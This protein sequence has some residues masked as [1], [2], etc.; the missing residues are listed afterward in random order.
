MIS[1]SL[2]FRRVRILLIVMTAAV[3]AMVVQLIRVQFGTYAPVFAMWVEAAQDTEDEVSPDR[4]LIYDRDGD[5]LATNVPMYYLEIEVFQLTPASRKQIAAV[6]SQALILPYEDLYRQL[7]ID[8]GSVG[9][10]RI[11]LT[12]EVAGE[13][14][15]PITVDQVAADMLRA[16][17]LDPEAPDLSGLKLVPAPKREY[18]ASYLAGHVMGFVNQEGKGYFGV[19][20]FYDDWLAGKP[21]T[22]ERG[23]IP[24]EARLE[25][26]PPAG[27]NLVLTIDLDIQQM[28]EEILREAIENASAESGQILVMDPR[29]GEILG[30]AI[31]PGLNPNNYEPWL[32]ERGVTTAELMELEGDQDEAVINPAVGGQFEPGSTFKVL[33]MAAALDAGVV[34][35]DTEFIDTGQI[36]VGGVRIRNWNGGAW[37]PQTME[38]CMEHSLNVCLAW[39]S[40]E[41]LGASTFYEYLAAFGIGR[42]TGIDVAGEVAGQLRTPRHP[43]W[44]E[45][46]LGTNAFGQGVSVTPVQLL[47]SV[48]AVANDGIMMQP[49]IVRA[50]VGPEGAYWPKPTVLGR[51]ISKETADELNEMLAESIAGETHLA[52]VNGYRLAGKTGTA[53]IPT[54]KGYDERWTIASF[55]GWGPVYD[56]QFIVL[57]RIDKP[58]SSPWGSVVAAPVFRDV[59]ERLVTMLEI[60]P[61]HIY[62]QLVAEE[63]EQS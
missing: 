17:L 61:D 41:K 26:D 25:P 46:D 57:V 55:I 13:D 40:S 27:V 58:E 1:E 63:S 5:L 48:G 28:L 56:P 52:S 18:P 49:H 9:Q 37:G 19:E 30:L 22:I 15:W 39:L 16:F 32:E 20:G 11:R 50:V 29:T 12:R 23:Y 51:P 21:V 59:V 45:A 35:P 54:E 42:G 8:W 44:T 6:L 10:Y 4:G 14:R 31:Q 62:E 33:T 43:E 24:L 47:A 7:T 60:P 38:G 3:L 36:E 53:Q 34:E 2:P